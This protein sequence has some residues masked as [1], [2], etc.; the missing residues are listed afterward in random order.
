MRLLRLGSLNVSVCNQEQRNEKL[1]VNDL[2]EPGFSVLCEIN[3]EVRREE[4]LG[5]S[6]GLREMRKNMAEQE[7]EVVPILPKQERN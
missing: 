2:Q 4:L 3:L 7:R 6:R 5:N 1:K